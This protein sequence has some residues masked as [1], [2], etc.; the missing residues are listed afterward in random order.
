MPAYYTLLYYMYHHEYMYIIHVHACLIA[1]QVYMIEANQSF[2][3]MSTPLG[4]KKRRLSESA[5]SRLSIIPT[6]TWM[7]KS[8]VTESDD[9]EDFEVK[10]K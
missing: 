9:D 7:E 2:Y 4:D 8:F 5:V 3:Q 1:L 10:K 6:C